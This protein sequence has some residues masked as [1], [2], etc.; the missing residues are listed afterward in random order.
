MKKTALVIMAAG[1]GSRYGNGIKQL[2]PVGPHQELIMDYSIRDAVEAG[3]DKVVFILRREIEEEFRKVIGSRI[4]QIVETEYAF[5]ELADLPEGFSVP[6]GRK[7]PW[8]TGQ[9]VLAAR[10]LLHEPFAVI[11]ADDYYGKTAYKKIH[12]YLAQDD[13][14]QSGRLPFCMVGF[15]L[16]NTLS[17]HGSVT[18]GICHIE[19]GDLT[20]VTETRNI[21]RSEDGAEIRLPDGTVRSLDPESLVSMNMWGMTPEAIGVLSEG[22]EDFLS[23]L[24]REG[25]PQEYLLPE[26]IDGLIK[27]NRASVHVLESS[28][29]WFGVTYQED[30][31]SVQEA[32][33]KLTETGVYPD[34]L[35][36]DRS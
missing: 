13:T 31:A 22:F 6:E 36:P 5:Q 26:W 14:V 12:D 35:Y 33:R 19:N 17:D 11:N 16:G 15:R 1:I 30:R 7:K 25:S 24:G 21:F 4:D 8:G 9:A 27:A 23:A 29:E 2:A 20:G 18:R 32:F 28:D 3:F 10:N 34:G